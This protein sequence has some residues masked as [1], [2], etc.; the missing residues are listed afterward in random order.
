MDGTPQLEACGFPLEGWIPAAVEGLQDLLLAE[1]QGEVLN[2]AW[3]MMQPAWY[4]VI[5][6]NSVAPVLILPV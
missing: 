3:S 4:F 2:L 5:A 1:A 6:V